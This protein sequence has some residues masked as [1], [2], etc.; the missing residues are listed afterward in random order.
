MKKLKLWWVLLLLL[1]P[2][3]NGAQPVQKG[4]PLP[5]DLE[6]PMPPI[7]VKADGKWWLV[8]ELHVTNFHTNNVELVRVEVL[9]EGAKK[10]IAT[11]SDEELSL[12]F[13]PATPV[14]SKLPEQ[15]ERVIGPAMRAVIYLLIIVDQEADVPTALGHRL[16]FKGDSPVGNSEDI[17]EGGQVTVGRKKPLV[18]GPPLRGEG[19]V[20]GR[21][22]SNESIHRR[23]S[24]VI[25]KARIPQRFAIDFWRM[26]ADGSPVSS[27]HRYVGGGLDFETRA[28][29]KNANWLAYGAEVLAVAN[30]VVSDL[31]DGIPENEMGSGEKAVPITL[32]TVAGNHV[33]IDLGNKN[34]AGYAHL[35]PKSIRVR[36]GQKV[37][38]GQVLAL[39]GNS[40]HSDAP[41]LHFQVTDGNSVVGAEGIPYVF[42]SFDLQGILPAAELGRW[43]PSSTAKANKRRREI[44]TENSVIRFP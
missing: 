28:D 30:G 25:G 17:V 2:L 8:Y 9:R 42:E 13:A 4:L 10:P 14:H 27:P 37:R 34:F 11:Y 6:I 31:K 5:V 40:G 44:P 33:I 22:P 15:P 26:D 36:V 32:E 21:G 19:W 16:V 38:R 41:H 39:L 43:K 23:A 35:Q 3:Q 7:P 20:A 1:F 12:R 18:L 29:A 24:V